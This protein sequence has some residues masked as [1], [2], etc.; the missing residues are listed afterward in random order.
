MCFYH[1]RSGTR[2]KRVQLQTAFGFRQTWAA[3]LWI[4][5]WCVTVASRQRNLSIQPPPTFCLRCLWPTWKANGNALTSYFEPLHC[6]SALMLLKQLWPVGLW[7]NPH[8]VEKLPE[9]LRWEGFLWQV[10]SSPRRRY[11]ASHGRI[12]WLW[13]DAGVSAL[14]SV[15]YSSKLWF[16]MTDIIVLVPCSCLSTLYLREIKRNPT[17]CVIPAS[18]NSVEEKQHK[19]LM[20]VVRC[21]WSLI[22]TVA[23]ARCNLA[24]LQF[25]EILKY[26]ERCGLSLSRHK[27]NVMLLPQE[28]KINT[29]AMFPRRNRT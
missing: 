15:G 20:R 18:V 5:L 16:K 21:L 9:E 10:L 13:S 25:L 28:L 11:K 3:E 26:S 1:R 19:N 27:G 2:S 17:Q 6:T 14:W 23:L 8:W 24:W 4:S 29:P 12:Y 7:Q 22:I